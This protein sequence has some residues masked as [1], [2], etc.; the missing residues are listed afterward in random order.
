MTE[1]KN[2]RDGLRVGHYIVRV[3]IAG[4]EM[5]MYRLHCRLEQSFLQTAG[6]RA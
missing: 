5:R 6:S 4:E 2:D 3:G 1:R